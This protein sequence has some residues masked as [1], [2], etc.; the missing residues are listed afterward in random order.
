M[1]K[2][3]LK[4]NFFLFFF[5][6]PFLLYSRENY[7]LL[8]L[9]T[10][11]A[12]HLSLYGYEKD[13]TPFLKSLK[14]NSIVFE[15]AYSLVP[16]TFPSHT[17]MLSGKTPFETGIFLNGQKL[18]EEES[19]LPKY[20]KKK[21]YQTA[22]FVSSAI[23]NSMFG[24]SQGFDTYS[25]VPPEKGE[26]IKERSCKKTNEEVF[27]FLKEN[28]KP[29]FLWVHYFEP[30]SPYDPPEPYRSQFENPYDGE[31]R[32]MDECVKELFQKL[33]EN[34]TIVIAGDHGEMLGEHGEDEHGVLL[35]EPAIRVPLIILNKKLKPGVRKE[36]FSL[37]E[38]FPTFLGFLEKKEMGLLKEK[39][40]ET[41]IS[42][43]LYGREV[44]GFYPAW[45]SIKDGFKLINYGNNDYLLFNLKEDPKEKNNI[46]SRDNPL[47]R[48]LKK[49]QDKNPFPD[50]L[51]IA[52]KDEDKKVLTS[53]GYSLPKKTEKLIHPEKGLLLDRDLKKA[54]KLMEEENYRE[55]EFL[56][57][58]ILKREPNHS[59][60]KKTLGKL[61]LKTGEKEK[62][63]GAF[64]NFAMG[65]EKKPREIA[66]KSFLEGDYETAIKIMEGEIQSNP[67]L[68]SNYGEL[69]SYYY[70]TKK[71]DKLEKLYENS[72]KYKVSS[73]GLWSFLGLLYIRNNKYS[74]AEKLFEDALKLN[75]KLPEALKGKAMV[76]YQ[77]KEYQEALKYI[78]N[79]IAISSKD[80][81][82]HYIKGKILKD[83]ENP[84][85]AKESFLKAKEL[86]KDENSGE[87]LK[88]ELEG[89]K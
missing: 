67:L 88:K 39:N 13:T 51:K 9:D 54:E 57:L 2:K 7:L 63:M 64:S 19:W 75:P 61:Y 50:N 16:L 43:T 46:F 10:V 76:L 42:S 30:H 27:K 79:Y 72:K 32:V 23:L 59:E 84:E 65:E 52:L 25:D 62:A 53:L 81:E 35:Y 5:F 68:P 28:K 55:A 33:P 86:L 12:D 24:L 20:F 83:F 70:A 44:M 6:F 18:E 3:I 74:E 45:A 49:I 69:A 60:A 4:N 29:F 80:W 36:Y 48:E 66:R 21:G 41:I 40:E 8:T 56:L 71:Y 34:T 78:E 85:L 26:V 31:L 37:K 73:P 1:F 14:E 47:V 58:S 15:N 87:F 11:R 17:T 82:G 22:A 77:K 89:I 38:I